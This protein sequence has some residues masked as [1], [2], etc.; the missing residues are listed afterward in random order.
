MTV[1]RSN[2]FRFALVTALAAFVQMPAATAAPSYTVT[3]LGT[4]GG[5]ASEPRGINNLGQVVGSA[6]AA[7]ATSAQATLFGATPAANRALGT[8]GGSFSYATAVN[9]SGKV[10]GLAATAADFAER[11]TLFSTSGNANIDLGTLGGRY[12]IAKDIN[13]SGRVVGWAGNA[14]EQDRATLFDPSGP[15]NA[16]RRAK[17]RVVHQRRR[18]GCGLRADCDQRLPCCAVRHHRRWRQHRPRH[19]RRRR[20]PCFRCQQQRAGGRMGQSQ[21]RGRGA[22]NALQHDRRFKC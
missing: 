7:G 18:S 3:D 12:S 13:A 22:R 19:P 16:R 17:Q 5:T 6:K 1:F 4:L 20:Q 11:A 15:W 9:D 8:L 21:W 2:T 14:S 10:V